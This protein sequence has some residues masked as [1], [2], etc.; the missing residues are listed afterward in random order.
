MTCK[1]NKLIVGGNLTRDP[2]LKSSGEGKSFAKIGIAV[3]GGFGKNKSTAFLDVTMFGKRAESFCQHHSKGSGAMLDGELRME[4]WD[5]K[6]TGEKR[7]K[8]V[9]IANDWSFNESAKKAE[10]EVPADPDS[11]LPF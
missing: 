9:M 2:E 8:V 11:G 3:D 10:A 7:S 4:T 6:K 1:F 5:D